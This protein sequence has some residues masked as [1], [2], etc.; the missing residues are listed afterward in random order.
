LTRILGI[1]P[2][3]RVTGYGIIDTDGVRTAHRASGRIV[4]ADTGVEARLRAIFE[5]LRSVLAE[6]RPEEVAIEDVFVA[7]NA[8]SALKLGQA[9]AAALLPGVLEGLPLFEYTPA[10]VKQA[11]TGHGRA[12]KGQ[13][14][15]MVRVLLRLPEALP[16]DVSDALAVALCHAH[17][18]TTL[19][20]LPEARRYRAGRLR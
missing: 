3:S 10:R 6:H 4:P 13:V 1:D 15:Q 14:Q 2:G 8:A 9:R 16:E 11:V 12:E 5:G 20:R 7:R 18:R 17:T 19:G